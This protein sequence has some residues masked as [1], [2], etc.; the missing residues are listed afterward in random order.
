VYIDGLQA[1]MLQNTKNYTAYVS[2]GFVV[3]NDGFTKHYYAGAERVLSKLGTGEF[4]NKFTATN[5]VLTAGNRNYIQRQQQLQAGIE[6]QYKELAIP[7]GN[8]TQKANL[9]QPENTGQPLPTTTGNNDIPRGWPRE[10]KFNE[11]GDVPG[12]PIQFGEAITNENVRAGYG[13]TKNALE[14]ADQYFYH[15]DHLGSTSIITDKAGAATQFVAYLPFGEGL[16]DEHSTRKE[17]PYKFSGKELDEETGLYYYG[18]RYY[19]PHGSVW[20]SADPLQEKYPNVGAYVY[21]AQNPIRFI[22]PDGNTLEERVAA[23]AQIR[24]YI[25]NPYS[26]MD[27]SETFDRSVRTSTELGTLKTGKG[28]PKANGQGYWANGVASIVSHSI[29]IPIG[30][31]QIGSAVTFRSGR[32]D[33]KGEEGQYDHVGMVTNIKRDDDGN[34]VSFNFIHSSSKGVNEQTYDMEKGVAGFQLKG[35]FAWDTQEINLPAVDIIEKMP[36]NTPSLGLKIPPIDD[37]I[38]PP[39]KIEQ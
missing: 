28:M 24:T 27:C 12:P 11:K 23:V 19:E 3:K 32:S 7:P 36:D 8:P 35:V 1:G 15:P 4:N 2:A 26:T 16:V 5:K 39:L 17:M 21:C 25:G 6:A 37:I 10:P 34:I 31:V 30:D 18:A 9:G 13:Y 33:H 20:I 14:E 22:D 29:E 38:I